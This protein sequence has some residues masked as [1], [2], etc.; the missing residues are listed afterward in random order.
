[1]NRLLTDFEF[2][3]LVNAAQKKSKFVGSGTLTGTY[4]F[5]YESGIIKPSLTKNSNNFYDFILTDYGYEY[6]RGLLEF[7]NL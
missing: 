7:T 2:D 5:L 1:M 4:K 6:A 3:S